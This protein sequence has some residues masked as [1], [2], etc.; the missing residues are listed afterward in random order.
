VV[1]D[2]LFVGLTLACLPVICS[3]LCL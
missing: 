2:R 1:F 3:S